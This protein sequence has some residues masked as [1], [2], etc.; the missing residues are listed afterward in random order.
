[1]KFY[2]QLDQVDCGPTCVAMIASHYGKKYPLNF[3]RE[4]SHL[5][6]EGVS[7]LSIGEAAKKL[8]FDTLYAKINARSLESTPLPCILHWN[9]NH[10]VVLRSVVTNPFNG[11]RSYKIADPSVGFI[12]LS[13]ETFTEHWAQDNNEGVA[14]FLDPTPEFYKT[15]PPE[16]ESFSFGYF[17]KYIGPFKKQLFLMLLLLLGGNVINLFFP[18]LTQKLVDRG[19]NAKDLDFVTIILLSQVGLVVGSIAIQIFRNWITLVVGT[20]INIKIIS[21]FLTKILKLP[22][23]FFE[24]KML[25]DFNQRIQDH[26]RIENFLTSQSLMTFF[27]AISLVFLVGAIWHYDL[28]ILVVYVSLTSLSLCWSLYWLKKRKLLDHFKFQLRSENQNSLIE[29]FS[30]VSEMKLNNLEG[31]KRGEWEE[32]QMKLYKLNTRILKFDQ[33]QMSGY[34]IVN[35]LKNIFVTYLAATYVIQGHMTLGVLLSVSYIIGQLNGPINQL[36]TFFRSLQDAKLSFARLQEVH[37]NPEEENEGQLKLERNKAADYKQ[38]K[39]GIVIRN[40]SFQFEG[41]KSNYILKDVNAIIPKGKVTAIVGSSG[42]GKTTLL[43]ILL[44]FYNPTKGDVTVDNINLDR[45]SAKSLRE[46]SGVV[47]QDGFL[48]SDTI[49]R[50]IVMNDLEYNEDKL[51]GA[52]KIANIGDFLQS[53]PL[54]M[55]TKVGPNG[56]TLSGGQRQRLLI[57]RAVYKDP[58]FLFFDEATSSLDAENERIIH[59]NLQDFFKGRTVVIIAHRLSTVRKADNILVLEKGQIVEEGTHNELIIKRSSY[60]HLV[61]NQL[62]LGA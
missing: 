1:M 31:L 13:E 46:H 22:M 35:Q 27:S 18:F 53:L 3:L 45:I 49:F 57:A 19:V 23:K 4:H 28:R 41:P 24:S 37:Q 30:G 56:T 50:N 59:D 5:T 36:L 12:R 40:L 29:I 6:R 8:G 55:N 16:E 7:L 21:D 32:I 42:S 43:K 48:F 11:K 26:E 34:E 54:G 62:E 38:I 17:L 44:K 2:N 52:I 15:R 10:F 39:S 14:L 51:I 47:M 20:K 61:K 58:E 60:Y 33:V 9:Q 25:G